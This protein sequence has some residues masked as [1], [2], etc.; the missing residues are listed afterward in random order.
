MS[1]RNISI[2]I[3]TASGEHNSS[4]QIVRKLDAQSLRSIGKIYQRLFARE[5]DIAHHTSLKLGSWLLQQNL[6]QSTCHSIDILTRTQCC[7]LVFLQ[8][9]KLLHLN[10]LGIKIKS[11]AQ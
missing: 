7:R 8:Q 3:L 2:T 1:N 9:L 6:H 5:Q 4:R 11:A 10:I